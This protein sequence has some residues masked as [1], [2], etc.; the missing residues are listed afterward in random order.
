MKLQH[1]ILFQFAKPR[2]IPKDVGFVIIIATEND[3]DGYKAK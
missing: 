2:I 3:A 1:R